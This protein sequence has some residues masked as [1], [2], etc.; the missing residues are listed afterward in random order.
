MESTNELFLGLFLEKSTVLSRRISKISSFNIRQTN[1]QNDEFS[2]LFQFVEPRRVVAAT[3][4]IHFLPLAIFQTKTSSRSNSFDRLGPMFSPPSTRFEENL[5]VK[6]NV[7]LIKNAV[8]AGRVRLKEKDN[9]K[10]N[11]SSRRSSNDESV[12][13]FL[14][15]S[16]VKFAVN[17][18]TDR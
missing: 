15:P 4:E 5:E 11:D 2:F 1:A 10:V 13:F 8:L 7:N 12:H 17:R 9:F 16:R 14:K 18:E 6:S 3:R